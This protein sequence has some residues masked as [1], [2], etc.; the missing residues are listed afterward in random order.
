MI[1]VTVSLIVIAFTRSVCHEYIY[2][3]ASGGLAILW[4]TGKK[5]LL[6]LVIV[7]TLHSDPQ[8][9]EIPM[10]RVKNWIFLPI[11]LERV[12]SQFLRYEIELGLRAV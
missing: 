3:Y 4:R 9:L 1:Q 8:K 6:N 2:I 7:L 5:E 11:Q 12:V 10:S